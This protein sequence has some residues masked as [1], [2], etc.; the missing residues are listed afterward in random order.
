MSRRSTR[1]AAGPIPER[2]LT[3]AEVADRIGMKPATVT[4]YA[5]IGRIRALRTGR[6]GAQLRYPEGAVTEYLSSLTA[7][8]G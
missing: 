3:T 8:N 4:H 6:P 5:R 1:A 2:L 7:A